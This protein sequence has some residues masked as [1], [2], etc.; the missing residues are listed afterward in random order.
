MRLVYEKPEGC[1]FEV[2]ARVR[3]REARGLV[4][5]ELASA[6]VVAYLDGIEGGV[7]L[8]RTLDGFS[9]WNVRELEIAPPIFD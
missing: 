7:K 5:S 1:E 4:G 3:L 9:C 8:D 6:V 2:G